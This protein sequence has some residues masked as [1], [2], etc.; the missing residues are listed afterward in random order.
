MEKTIKELY[1]RAEVIKLLER[2]AFH[3]SDNGDP[4][5]DPHSWLNRMEGVDD[6]HVDTNPNN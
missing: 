3:Y 4:E 1:T 6:G 5:T 2:I